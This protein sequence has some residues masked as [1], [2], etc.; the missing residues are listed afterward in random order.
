[1]MIT[2]YEG[3]HV[4]S[5]NHLVCEFSLFQ[6]QSPVPGITDNLGHDEASQVWIQVRLGSPHSSLI[7]DINRQIGS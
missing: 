7:V 1:M 2:A 3:I 6:M 4:P 5:Q